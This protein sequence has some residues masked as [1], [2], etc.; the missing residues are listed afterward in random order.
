MRGVTAFME[1]SEE[2]QDRDLIFP[3]SPLGCKS[4]GPSGRSGVA[5][6]TEFVGTRVVVLVLLTAV[7]LLKEQGAAGPAK[8]N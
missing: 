4:G 6:V 7:L 3:A 8:M 1:D 5:D 2:R